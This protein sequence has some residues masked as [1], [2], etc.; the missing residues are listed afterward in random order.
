MV[1]DAVGVD[2]AVVEAEGLVARDPDRNLRF[3]TVQVVG[4]DAG[5]LGA[6]DIRQVPGRQADDRGTARV[7]LAPPGGKIPRLN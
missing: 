3:D 7:D 1:G 4:V 6:G 5:D 2:S